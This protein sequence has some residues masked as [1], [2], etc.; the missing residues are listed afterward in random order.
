MS[1]RETYPAA[2]AMMIADAM[3]HL[4]SPVCDRVV[5]AGSLRRKKAE[6]GDIELLYI[7]AF[8]N[9]QLDM[10]TTGPVNLA[11]E[12]LGRMLAPGEILKRPGRAGGFT[13]GQWNKF[14]LH[15]SGIPID[16]FATTAERW[17]MSLV[18]RTGGRETNLKLTTGAQARGM[19]LNAYGAG[20]TKD[21]D[22]IP[23]ASEED[24]FALAGVPFHPPEGRL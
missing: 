3:L 4:L 8:G 19:T 11:D 17:W 15:R 20:F 14:A 1:A 24:V 23:V 5:V 13:W 21:G 18:I 7:P 2:Q 12:L 10:F 9:R 6:V 16:F 22:T